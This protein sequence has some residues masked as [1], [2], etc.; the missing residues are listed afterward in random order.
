MDRKELA[1]TVA[2]L[3]EELR[4]IPD[5]TETTACNLLAQCGYDVGQMEESALFDVDLALLR[6][7]RKAHITL[8]GSAYENMEIG[9]PFHIPFTVRNARGRIKCPRCGSMETAR[10][11]YGMP[12]FSE[13]LERRLRAGRLRLGGCCVSANDPKRYCNTCKKRF[14][15]EALLE[16][17]AGTE[18]VA[19]AVTEIQFSRH[20]FF[21]FKE[22]SISK[23]EDGA[24]VK[25]S[26]NVNADARDETFAIGKKKWNALVNALYDALYLNDWKHRTDSETAY[27]DGE[28]W[29]L[30]VKLT[31]RRK[32]SYSG[33]NAY[34]PYWD[35]LQKLLKPFI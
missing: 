35:E 28:E 1:E 22:V 17:E 10:I 29:E 19:D 2:D 7:A 23:T 14:G 8:D 20:S 5:G 9:L 13:E 24:C 15:A 11:L 31:N 25:T 3:V 26:G 4:E 21:R 12:A 32:R 18:R 27:L 6:A 30:T 33:C 34:P 16:T